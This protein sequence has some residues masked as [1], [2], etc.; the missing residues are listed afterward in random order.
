MQSPR[1]SF[2]QLR[3]ADPHGGPH[4]GPQVQ[5]RVQREILLQHIQ[6]SP[7]LSL[8]GFRSS[9]RGD[10][11]GG[12]GDPDVAPAAQAQRVEGGGHHRSFLRDNPG[13]VLHLHSNRATRAGDPCSS[14]EQDYQPLME[15][16]NQTVPCNKTLLWSKT[17]DL[18][19]D[20]AWVQP[21]LF[22]LE[23]TLLGYMADGLTWCGDPG[24]NVH[25]GRCVWEKVHRSDV[26]L[27]CI[28]CTSLT[29]KP[30]PMGESECRWTQGLSEPGDMEAES[31]GEGKL[32]TRALARS[33]GVVG[34]SVSSM[35]P[36]R[37]DEAR[38]LSL[39][40]GLQLQ[41]PRMMTQSWSLCSCP[42]F[43]E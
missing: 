7:D 35:F 15:L 25:Y 22:T 33:R 30:V 11:R 8:P 5:C 27:P 12:G 1:R 14:T 3:A 38:G 37:G 19:H 32:S 29:P 6:E 23:D 4:G 26:L 13:K 28:C 39:S 43:G 36:G 42:G 34:K 20:Y 9:G 17:R 31:K 21:D 2:P 16:T 10:H 24:S 18:V 40:D 41:L